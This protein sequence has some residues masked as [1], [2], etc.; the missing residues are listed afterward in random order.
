MLAEKILIA[1]PCSAETE[2]QVLQTALEI[3]KQI[4]NFIYRAG[5]WKP[6]T[7]PG[8]FEGIGE[9]ALDWLVQVKQVCKIDVATEVVNTNHVEKALKYGINVLW[10]GARTTVNPFYVEEIAQALKGSDVKV[11]IKNPIHP[12]IELWEGAVERI[13]KAGINKVGLIHRGF[14]TSS[15]TP[16]RNVPLWQLAIDMKLR[17]LDKPMICDISHICGNTYHLLEVANK[18]ASLDYQGLHIETHINPANALSDAKQQVTPQQLFNLLLE[19]KWSNSLQNQALEELKNI[20][21]QINLIDEELLQLLSARMKLA[22]KIGAIKQK[23]QLPILQAA[24]FNEMLKQRLNQAKQLG[25]SEDFIRLMFTSIHFE[26][27][28]HQNTLK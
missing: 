4:P 21:E 12:E 13:Q 19:V 7:K 26:S 15:F 25:L 11:F 9:P 1:G 5:I 22:E 16:F 20:R 10:I 17:H 28:N 27:I 14:K 23:N 8:F 18:A 6:R 3:K 24:H 2:E